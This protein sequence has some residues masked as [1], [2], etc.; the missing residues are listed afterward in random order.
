MIMRD[1][2]VE[3]FRNLDHLRFVNVHLNLHTQASSILPPSKSGRH[4]WDLPPRPSSQTQ[5]FLSHYVMHGHMLLSLR[6]LASRSV[7]HA[8]QSCGCFEGL[9]K[10]LFTLTA[11]YWLN[12]QFLQSINDCSLCSTTVGPVP[13]FFYSE[14][15]GDGVVLFF[16]FGAVAFHF[17]LSTLH[18]F[19]LPFSWPNHCNIN[20][21]GAGL[22]V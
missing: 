21:M 15:V 14:C 5:H 18:V 1:T 22:A 4:A 6:T 2:I 7:E 11:S 19:I 13:V 3:G 8:I 17:S 12:A 10:C 20:L 16:F 9:E